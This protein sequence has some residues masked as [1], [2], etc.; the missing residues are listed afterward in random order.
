M[1]ARHARLLESAAILFA[2]LLCFAGARSAQAQS[3]VCMVDSD[4]PNSA[5]GGDV[6]THT[7]GSF[8]CNPA[9]TQAGKGFDGW[10]ADSNG[11]AKDE[12]CKC[13]G[14]GAT[15]VGFFCTFT[16]PSDAPATGTGGAGASAGGGSG[17][18]AAG[19][20]GSAGTAGSGGGSTGTAGGA[21]GT[22]GAAG[23]SG[24]AGGDGGGGGCS[25]A[26]TTQ[27]SSA[28]AL[29]LA[30]VVSALPRRRRSAAVRQ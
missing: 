9:N 28:V 29:L 30:I 4:C 20:S 8:A 6:C 11:V 10:C 15:C 12:L 2:G 16:V 22:T 19:A 21:A 3:P 17:G 26:G 7:S 24:T 14:L 5:C 27:T 1:T 18:G 13:K 25:V 23:G